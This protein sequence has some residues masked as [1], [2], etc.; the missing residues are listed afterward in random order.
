MLKKQIM[1]QSICSQIL[2]SAS[3]LLLWQERHS[4]VSSIITLSLSLFQKRCH[5]HHKAATSSNINFTKWSPTKNIYKFLL[6][7]DHIELTLCPKCLEITPG[8]AKRNSDSSFAFTNAET[9]QRCK[10]QAYFLLLVSL[11]KQGQYCL[12]QTVKFPLRKISV[13]KSIMFFYEPHT[14]KLVRIKKKAAW[15]HIPI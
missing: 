10:S 15:C 13:H 11:V 7:W 2:N 1:A 9:K 4:V 14:F 12:I 3:P 5:C 6:F 8:W